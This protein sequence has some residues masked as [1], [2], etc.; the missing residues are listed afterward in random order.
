MTKTRSETARQN[1][2]PTTKS[3]KI[4]TILVPKDFIELITFLHEAN[5]IQFDLTKELLNRM[6]NDRSTNE[7]TIKQPSSRSPSPDELP[8]SGRPTSTKPLPSSHSSTS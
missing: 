7:L 6:E 2:K 1:Q 4:H 5:K 8:S 3:Q